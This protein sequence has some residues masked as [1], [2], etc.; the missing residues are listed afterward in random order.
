MA[1]KASLLLVVLSVLLAAYVLRRPSTLFPA[2]DGAV[3]PRAAAAVPTPEVS[4]PQPVSPAVATEAGPAEQEELSRDCAPQVKAIIADTGNRFRALV[5]DAFVS[6]GSMV[7][8]YRV[9]KVQADSVEFEKD[10]Q[11]WVEKLK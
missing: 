6:E 11:T 9:R 2:W 7:Q 4:Q 1:K 8:G 10:G 3:R 5:G